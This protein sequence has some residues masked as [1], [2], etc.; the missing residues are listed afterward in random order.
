LPRPLTIAIRRQPARWFCRHQMMC[1]TATPG[2]RAVLAQCRLGVG[3]GMRRTT[4]RIAGQAKQGPAVSAARC[5]GKGVPTGRSIE[6]SP[7]WGSLQSPTLG[8]MVVSRGKDRYYMNLESAQRGYWRWTL[9]KQTRPGTWTCPAL[10]K[11]AMSRPSATH[12]A[13]S[14]DA[15]P[16][17]QCPCDMVK[18]TLKP[19]GKSRSH[20]PCRCNVD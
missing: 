7:S 5:A 18:L 6:R 10:H 9:V 19:H 17:S 2:R 4:V 13:I 1:V 12:Y 8:S 11:H 15:W 16:R 3:S 14:V 20:P